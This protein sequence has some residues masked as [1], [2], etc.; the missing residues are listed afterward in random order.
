MRACDSVL[1]QIPENIAMNDDRKGL[2][3][4]D[5]VRWILLELEDMT[6]ERDRELEGIQRQNP[7]FEQ[8]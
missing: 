6:G 1:A 3:A 5:E 8:N 4:A 2:T 7:C